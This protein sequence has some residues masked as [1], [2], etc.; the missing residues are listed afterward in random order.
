MSL[1]GKNTSNSY[2]DLLN[3]DNGNNG[4][5]STARVVKDGDGGSSAI[6]LS[7]RHLYV[8]PNLNSSGS[9]VV[10]DVSSD[11]VLVAHTTDKVVKVNET[12]SIANTQYL[13]FFG[14]DIDTN[15]GTHYG[16]PLACGIQGTT[17]NAEVTFGTGTDPTT[18]TLSNNLDDVLHYMHYVDTNITVDAVNVMVGGTASSGD[19]LNFHLISLEP[20]DNETIDA[21]STV[22]V[23]ADDSG[24][25]T[26]GYGQFYRVAMDIQSAN[27]NAGYFLALTVEGNGTN[28][29]YSINAQIRYHLR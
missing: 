29:D 3:L 20:D 16:V 9:F 1:T 19:S 28:A 14:H 4:V 26:S 15:N 2:K 8:I 7:N 27:V 18:P 23:V 5:D 17:P 24:T 13:R 12:Q 25:S 6:K 22:A 21:F 10:T 11:A